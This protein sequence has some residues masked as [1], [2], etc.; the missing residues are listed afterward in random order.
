MSDAIY[1]SNGELT[2]EVCGKHE[3]GLGWPTPKLCMECGRKA[4]R[5]RTAEEILRSI[6]ADVEAMRVGTTSEFVGFGGSINHKDYTV[7]IDWPNL[8]ILIDEAKQIL[9]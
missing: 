1:D 3:L 7:D 5:K 9:K 4:P 2:C 6:V 8:A